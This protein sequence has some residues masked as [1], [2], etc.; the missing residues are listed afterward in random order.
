MNSYLALKCRSEQQVM[1]EFTKSIASKD[2]TKRTVALLHELT[3]FYVSINT[4]TDGSNN[5]IHDSVLKDLT[6]LLKAIKDKK[7]DQRIIKTVMTLLQRIA[8]QML[9]SHA[10]KQALAAVPVSSISAP[11]SPRG[12][13]TEAVMLALSSL[14]DLVAKSEITNAF[15]PRRVAAYKLFFVLSAAI[16]Q[17]ERPLS[18]T[19]SIQSSSAWTMLKLSASK[20]KGADKEL[21]TQLALLGA[22]F[23]VARH[24]PS[25]DSLDTLLP[26]FVHGAF[27]PNRHA[28]ATAL[29]LFDVVPTK[30]VDA[31][32]AHVNAP[33]FS[34]NTTDALATIYVLRLCGKIA[35][36]P[37]S[38]KCAGGTSSSSGT[39]NLL[40]FSFEAAK[41]VK[42]EEKVVTGPTIDAAVAARMSDLLLDI[43][44]QKHTFALAAAPASPTKH[45]AGTGTTLAPCSV[46]LTA[47]QEMALCQL[48]PKCFEKVRGGLSPFEIAANGIQLVVQTHAD[49]PLVLQRVARAVQVV[50]ECLD[51]CLVEY[52]AGGGH[53]DF[54]AKTTESM[55][56]ISL[57]PAFAPCLVKE[58]L[59]ALVWL[60]PRTASAAPR[61]SLSPK[62]STQQPPAATAW[63]RFLAQL[64]QLTTVPELDRGDIVLAMYRRATLFDLDVGLL[65]RAVALLLH[66]YRL[67]PCQWHADTML[68]LWRAL[69][70]KCVRAVANP[71]DL[72]ASFLA[73]LDHH[74][75]PSKPAQAQAVLY[76]KCLALRFVATS[77]AKLLAHPA[78][79]PSALD[80]LLRLTKS[81]MADESTVRRLS[82]QA[83]IALADACR[84]SQHDVMA[85]HVVQILHVLEKQPT[86]VGYRDLLAP[87]FTAPP[88]TTMV[89]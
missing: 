55:W 75:A 89:F 74:V 21:P 34:L 19:S 51:L 9:F 77:L 3:F 47:I 57:S 78:L 32:Y 23:Q 83:A 80:V 16:Q 86:S 76:M 5:H 29:R 22:A 39:H 37:V 48:A 20:K 44:M 41:P 66:W 24:A 73:V 65:H 13:K 72:F 11:M 46:L 15:P 4:D 27:L 12:D 38:S 82:V 2:Y 85:E 18:L 67:H 10:M 1:N 45:E 26:Q 61:T 63:M 87:F 33:S 28:A 8:E 43:C 49:H 30:V 56:D 84:Q 58:S 68:T 59:V 7:E 64:R 62:A 88:T 70:D 54:F 69:F 36:L 52:T 79:A 31:V 42:R 53:L 60:L 50:A 14:A 35:R 17:P 81:A 6:T 40:D 25:P 71:N